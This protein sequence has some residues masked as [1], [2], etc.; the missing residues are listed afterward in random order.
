MDKSSAKK[1]NLAITLA[2]FLYILFDHGIEIQDDSIVSLCTKITDEAQK[3]SVDQVVQA[4]IEA[5]P[6]GVRISE[7]NLTEFVNNQ[8]TDNNFQEL[9]PFELGKD[10]VDLVRESISSDASVDEVIAWL[11]E[12]IPDIDNGWSVDEDYTTVQRIRQY[13][14]KRGLPWIGRLAERTA[15]G[16]EEMWIMVEK[17]T[18]TVLCMDPYPWDDVDEEFMVDL[19]EFL[20]RWRLAG[21]VAIHLR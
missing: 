5:L 14:F 19:P 3:P 9:D 4:L 11:S 12:R 6:S 1:G 8:Q 21:S 16:L 17:V 20:L 15:D 2:T 13:E 10:L 18:D 7:A